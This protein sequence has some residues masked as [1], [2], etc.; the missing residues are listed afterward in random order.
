MNKKIFL[1]PNSNKS[2]A[3]A[4]AKIYEDKKEYILRISDC[5]NSIKLW[6]SIETE[7]EIN[8][9]IKKINNLIAIASELKECLVSIAS[10]MHAVNSIENKTPVRIKSYVRHEFLANIHGSKSS[11]IATKNKI[12]LSTL[13]KW[14]QNNDPE[15]IKPY[16]INLIAKLLKIKPHEVCDYEYNK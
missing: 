9:G 1:L 8:E 16:N 10:E 15:L 6:G 13:Q 12:D 7:E 2:M 14:L 4:H 5:H 3:A 11:K